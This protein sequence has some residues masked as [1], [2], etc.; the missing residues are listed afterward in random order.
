LREWY[1]ANQ[2]RLFDGMTARLIAETL[3]AQSTPDVDEAHRWLT[4]AMHTD[5][6]IGLKLDL[7]HDYACFADLYRTNG[8][9]KQALSNLTQARDLFAE[10]DAP[11]FVEEMDRRIE[12]EAQPS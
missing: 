6:S 11:G 7:A 9:R 10:C 12:L 4:A 3:L 5:R 2:L 1:E 8:D